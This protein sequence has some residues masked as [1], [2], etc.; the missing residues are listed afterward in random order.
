[1]NVLVLEDDSHRI[2]T[3]IDSFSKDNIKITDNSVDA[4]YYLD[5]YNF[6]L[7]FLAHDLGTGNG[8]GQDVAAHL[9]K[10]SHNDNNNAIIIIHSWNAYAVNKMLSY[11]PKAISMPFTKTIINNLNLDNII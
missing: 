4:I 3:F 8:C 7:I 2:S 9:Y 11:L 1:M 6:D 5:T 10:N